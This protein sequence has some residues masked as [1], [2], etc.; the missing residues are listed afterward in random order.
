M[1]V[2]SMTKPWSFH[3]GRVKAMIVPVWGS[4]QG[5]G[6]LTVNRGVPV[7]AG[8]GIGAARQRSEL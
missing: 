7:L 4:P 6:N 3:A 1:S 8:D 5:R 2:G